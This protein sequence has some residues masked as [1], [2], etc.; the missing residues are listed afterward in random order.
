MKIP[1]H[2]VVRLKDLV[3][4]LEQSKPQP[5][6]NDAKQPRVQQPPECEPFTATVAPEL[7]AFG[8]LAE[9]YDPRQRPHIER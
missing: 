8:M 3:E 1:D 9:I 5:K 4:R 2:L 6:T 7:R